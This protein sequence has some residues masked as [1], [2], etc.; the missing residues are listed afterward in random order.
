VVNIIAF[1]WHLT[2]K[3]YSDVA[4][5][6]AVGASLAPFDILG[7]FAYQYVVT[8]AHTYVMYGLVFDKSGWMGSKCVNIALPFSI[9]MP[10]FN[11]CPYTGRCGWIS[12][13]GTYVAGPSFHV[14]YETESPSVGTVLLRLGTKIS[15]HGILRDIQLDFSIPIYMYNIGVYMTREM[16]FQ[17]PTVFPEPTILII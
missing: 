5:R 14:S 2:Y 13:K 1:N 11:F 4:E 16:A 3:P 12:H 7:L 9:P 15:K 8:V 6:E 17:I 10:T